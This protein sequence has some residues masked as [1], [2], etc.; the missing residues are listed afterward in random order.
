MC[1][2][3]HKPKNINITEEV[4]RQCWM[5]N[6]DGVGFMYAEN[7]HL[8][9]EKGFMRLKDVFP[10]YDRLKDKELLIHF[11]YGT[12]GF[13]CPEHC[14]PFYINPNLAVM[15]NGHFMVDTKPEETDTMWVVNNIFKSLPPNF[16]KQEGM[17]KLVEMAADTSK[18]V[19]MDNTGAIIKTS[20][21]DWLTIN[22][23]Q[24]SNDNWVPRKKIHSFPNMAHIWR[25]HD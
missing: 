11:R 20:A 23:C 3:I 1:V 24:F 22:D 19:F 13:I 8:A 5:A 25:E 16:L 12:A 6:P 10:A 14:H 2:I 18:L 9:S 7:G 21:N 4:I 17:F 15:H